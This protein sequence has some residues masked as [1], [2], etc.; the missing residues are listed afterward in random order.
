MS[1][2]LEQHYCPRT[3]FPSMSWSGFIFP[4]LEHLYKNVFTAS[5]PKRSVRNVG[6]SFVSKKRTRSGSN[7][8]SRVGKPC[9]ENTNSAA[10]PHARFLD[11]CVTK[12][13]GGAKVARDYQDWRTIP[14]EGGESFVVVVATNPL[15]IAHLNSLLTASI[16]PLH[17]LLTIC[18]LSLL[19]RPLSLSPSSSRQARCRPDLRCRRSRRWKSLQ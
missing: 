10:Y 4:E 15:F 5:F 3:L 6:C 9:L 18:C 2:C 11:S 13:G 7:V 16:V 14:V 1:F 12:Q 8:S 19:L 17:C